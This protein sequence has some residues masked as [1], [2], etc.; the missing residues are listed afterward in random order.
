[1]DIEKLKD[2]YI[3]EEILTLTFSGGLSTRSDKHPVYEKHVSEDKKEEFKKFKDDVKK[4]LEKYK[5][6]Y[7]KGEISSEEHIKNIMEFAKELTEKHHKI[8]HNNKFRIGIAQKLLNLYLKYLWVLGRID[9]PPH[10]PF[11]NKIITKLSKESKVIE[12]MRIRWTCLDN[13]E[14]YKK[15]VK[16][17]VNLVKP[18]SLA[19][20]E[21]EFWERERNKNKSHPK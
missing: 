13:I 18:L 14:D 7:E 4:K 16:E 5:K 12:D 6:I 3:E 2:N 19:E 21:L 15:L 11:D 1:M 10:C 9:E 8:L 17:A 20:W